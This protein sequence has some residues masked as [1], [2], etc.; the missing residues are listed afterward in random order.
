M[1]VLKFKC[2][3]CNEIIKDVALYEQTEK[4]Y[5][6]TDFAVQKITLSKKGKPKV[7]HLYV[8]PFCKHLLNNATLGVVN[9]IQE[10]I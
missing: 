3:F 1:K 8:C 7:K 2:G 6:N 9:E 5:H 10:E 4:Y